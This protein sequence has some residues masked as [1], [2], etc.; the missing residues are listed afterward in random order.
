MAYLFAGV[1]E[2]NV[3]VGWLLVRIYLEVFG[4]IIVVYDKTELKW[5]R[6]EHY[7]TECLETFDTEYQGPP[8]R[9]QD[10]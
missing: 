5:N 6:Q 1:K 10:H 4:Q 9:A 2:T 7:E 8:S 3:S